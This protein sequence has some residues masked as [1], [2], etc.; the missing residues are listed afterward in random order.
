MN[1][2]AGWKHRIDLVN[3][4]GIRNSR[5]GLDV[6]KFGPFWKCVTSSLL[7]ELLGLKSVGFQLD[8]FIVLPKSMP[9]L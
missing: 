3:V 5:A 2:V 8:G 6:R 9:L 4:N 1:A 7:D